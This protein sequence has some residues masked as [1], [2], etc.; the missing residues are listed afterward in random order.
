MRILLFCPTHHLERETINSIHGLIVPDGV[1]LDTLFTRDNPHG[2]QHGRNIIY[3]YQKAERITKAEAYDYLLTIEND[4]IVPPDALVKL[5]A[6]DADIA[7]GVYVF[8]KGKPTINILRADD[9]QESYSLSVNLRAWKKVFGKVI[10]CN[11]LG[12]GCTLIKASVFDVLTLHSETG[13]DGDSQMAHE[14]RRLGLTQRADTSI[15]CGH[16]R[17]DGTVLWPT[18]DGIKEI[19]KRQPLETRLIIPNQMIAFW[20][21][22]DVSIIMRTNEPC[23]I[24]YENAGVFVNAG[25]AAYA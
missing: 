21:P 12:F 10:E 5:L 16:K 20:T 3:N 22:E 15:L 17:P 18:I 11:G 8:R 1:M 24:D 13:H 4:M 25:M 2:P 7:Y 6:V 19:G 14:A 9:T 23:L